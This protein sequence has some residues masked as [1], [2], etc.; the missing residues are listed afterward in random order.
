MK[1]LVISNFYP[2]H[3]VGGYELACA[4]VVEF[5]QRRGAEVLVLTQRGLPSTKLVHRV[6]RFFQPAATAGERKSLRNV[7]NAYFDLQNR[8]VVQAACHRF[9]PD[10]VL[11]FN[12]TNLG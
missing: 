6:L 12:P 5:L 3:Y 2:P 1:V 9:Q 10:A 8:R 7:R 4:E 11:V